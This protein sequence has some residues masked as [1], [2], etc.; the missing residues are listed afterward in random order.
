MEGEL[1][2]SIQKPPE[3]VQAAIPEQ[4][5]SF[6]PEKFLAKEE[7]GFVGPREKCA[8][9][10]LGLGALAV[11]S[12]VVMLFGALFS[13][14][15]IALSLYGLKSNYQKHARL[16]LGLSALGLFA[17]LWYLFAASHG[18]INYNY[19]TGEFWSGGRST[20]QITK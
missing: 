1:Y 4:K 20:E 12:W 13:L 15:G 8:L 6:I 11:I 5:I 17:S 9:I 10:G 2:N 16:G 7:R 19:F 14:L 3:N 18:M